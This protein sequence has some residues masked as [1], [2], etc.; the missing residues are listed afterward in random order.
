MEESQKEIST[1]KQQLKNLTLAQYVYRRNGVPLGSSNSLHNMLHRSL[2]ASSFARFWQYWNPI[3]GYGLG[4]YVYSPLQRVL[5]RTVA[6]IMTFVA[7]GGI[8]D[9]VTSAV[10]GSVAFLFTPWFFLLGVG[11]VLGRGARMD[12]SSRSWLVRA[13]INLT[14]IIVCLALTLIARRVF[15]IP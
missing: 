8:H 6:L 5:P 9:L 15:N 3:F 10:R 13:G 14:Y 4:K 12:L 1:R 11:V 7:S 2:G